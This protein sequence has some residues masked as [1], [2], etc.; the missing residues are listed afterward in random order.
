MIST[1]LGHGGQRGSLVGEH[2]HGIEEGRRALGIKG[3]ES[4]TGESRV[5]HL[6]RPCVGPLPLGEPNQA[7]EIMPTVPNAPASEGASGI[8]GCHRSHTHK[9]EE[10]SWGG[11]ERERKVEK[12]DGNTQRIEMGLWRIARQQMGVWAHLS[13]A[14]RKHK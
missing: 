14:L 13:S 9:W 4:R 5:S 12:V 6:S 11:R 7:T 3:K 10:K 8:V 1:Q 2:D